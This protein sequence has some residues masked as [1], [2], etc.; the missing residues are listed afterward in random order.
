MQET[1]KYHRIRV[2]AVSQGEGSSAPV[3]T[4]NSTFYHFSGVIV[5]TVT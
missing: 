5:N 4:P 2:T 1:L 3:F